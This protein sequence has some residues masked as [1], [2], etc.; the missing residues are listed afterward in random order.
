MHHKRQRQL[1][2]KRHGSR[3]M[4]AKE[5]EKQSLSQGKTQIT[6]TIAILKTLFYKINNLLVLSAI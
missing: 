5:V 2:I 3:Q 1:R 4:S 6:K